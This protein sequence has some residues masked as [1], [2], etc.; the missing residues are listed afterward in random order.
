LA[1]AARAS[2]TTSGCAVAS[3]VLP[4]WG[5]GSGCAATSTT[6]SGEPR[7]TVGG[8]PHSQPDPQHRAGGVAGPCRAQLA[9]REGGAPGGC[10]AGRSRRRWRRRL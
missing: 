3:S 8:R 10:Q 2:A 4:T 5:R 6:S 7:P 9:V 1:S